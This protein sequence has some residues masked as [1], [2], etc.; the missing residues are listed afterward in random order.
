MLAPPFWGILPQSLLTCLWRSSYK[1]N[2]ARETRPCEPSVTGHGWGGGWQEM[3]NSCSASCPWREAFHLVLK[4]AP[5]RCRLH[6]SQ[7]G[8]QQ[9][10]SHSL[11][12]PPALFLLLLPWLLLPRNTF[13]IDS[14]GF[15]HP[16]LCFNRLHTKILCGNSF[17]RHTEGKRLHSLPEPVQRGESRQAGGGENTRMWQGL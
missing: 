2:P 12:P 16:W 6:C 11:C 8:C 4:G 7:Q 5:V 17:H 13:P 10:P 15:T 9:H 3:A 1:H 14:Q